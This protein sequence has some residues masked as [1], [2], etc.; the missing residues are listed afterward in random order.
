MNVISLGLAEALKYGAIALKTRGFSGLTMNTACG[1]VSELTHFMSFEMGVFGIWRR[2]DA[3]IRPNNARGRELHLLL[4]LPWLHSVNAEILIRS[5]QIRLG[6]P[7]RGEKTVII[8]GPVF[9]E[10]EGN[11]LILYPK[12]MK[13]VMKPVDQ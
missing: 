11:R 5:S 3:F 6:D 10:S 1:G 9:M 13:P 7:E 12:G 4:G 8:Q 2:I